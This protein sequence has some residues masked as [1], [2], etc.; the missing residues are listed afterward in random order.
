MRGNING[1]G[2]FSNKQGSNLL[3]TGELAL[4]GRKGISLN[5]TLR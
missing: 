5:L 2:N 3:K 4:G 1:T